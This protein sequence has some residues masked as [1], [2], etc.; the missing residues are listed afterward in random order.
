MNRTLFILVI[1]QSLCLTMSQGSG[2]NPGDMKAQ[3]F[4]IQDR[5]L[6]NT[7]KTENEPLL[8]QSYIRTDTTDN[9]RKKKLKTVRGLSLK[10]KTEINAKRNL[11]VTNDSENGLNRNQNLTNKSPNPKANPDRLLNVLGPKFPIYSAMPINPEN[12]NLPFV[13]GG[14]L[15]PVAQID[16]CN[17]KTLPAVDSAATFSGVVLY[18]YEH[19]L[20]MKHF[21]YFKH[22]ISELKTKIMPMKDSWVVEIVSDD[23]VHSQLSD[24]NASL[25]VYPNLIIGQAPFE[26]VDYDLRCA[27]DVNRSNKGKTSCNNN[28]PKVDEN[29]RLIMKQI[30]SGYHLAINRY[31]KVVNDK[32]PEGALGQKYLVTYDITPNGSVD[33]KSFKQPVGFHMLDEF[34]FVSAANSQKRQKLER[35]LTNEEVKSSNKSANRKLSGGKAD[36]ALKETP[37]V[38]RLTQWIMKNLK[39]SLSQQIPQSCAEDIKKRLEDPYKNTLNTMA[40]CHHDTTALKY[41]GRHGVLAFRID[42]VATK[43]KPWYDQL[44]GIS[45]EKWTEADTIETRHF[46]FYVL[47]MITGTFSQASKFYLYSAYYF[48]SKS[49]ISGDGQSNSDNMFSIPLDSSDNSGVP[50]FSRDNKNNVEYI[51][52][53]SGVSEDIKVCKNAITGIKLGMFEAA[54]KFL[55]AAPPRDLAD[56]VAA[57]RPKNEKIQTNLSEDTD[58]FNTN[59]SQKVE[60]LKSSGNQQQLRTKSAETERNTRSGVVVGKNRG[61]LNR[62]LGKTAAK[63]PE[64]LEAEQELK[65]A[66]SFAWCLTAKAKPPGLKSQGANDCDDLINMVNRFLD[67]DETSQSKMAKKLYS[68]F[69]KCSEKCD[70][71]K[72]SVDFLI[73]FSPEIKH[74]PIITVQATIS[75]T[76]NRNKLISIAGKRSAGSGGKSILDY[77]SLLKIVEVP[78]EDQAYEVIEKVC[79][80]IRL[81]FAGFF[82]G[83]FKCFNFTTNSVDKKN[84]ELDGYLKIYDTVTQ[85]LEIFH[86]YLANLIRTQFTLQAV[87]INIEKLFV[88]GENSNL[89][90]IKNSKIELTAK[91]LLGLEMFGHEKSN[92]DGLHPYASGPITFLINS[93][94]TKNMPVQVRIQSSGATIISVNFKVGSVELNLAIPRIFAAEIEKQTLD[95]ILKFDKLAKIYGELL[96]IKDVNQV[97]D[98]ETVEN[99]PFY[100]FAAEIKKHMNDISTCQ[101]MYFEKTFVKVINGWIDKTFIELITD[102]GSYKAIMTEWGNR[103]Y[104]DDYIGTY[105]DFD[106]EVK[107]WIRKESDFNLFK[108]NIY[109]FDYVLIL[110][111]AVVKYLLENDNSRLISVNPQLKQNPPDTTSETQNVQLDLELYDG[112]A[113]KNWAGNLPDDESEN[114]WLYKDNGNETPKVD[115]SED[116]FGKVKE[117]RE[118]Y[119]FNHVMLIYGI[120][121]VV[122]SDQ[123]PG[124]E[125]GRL[126]RVSLYE[127]R[128]GPLNLVHVI[129]TTQYFMWEYLHGFE[130]Y[131]MLWM[132]MNEALKEVLAQYNDMAK[133]ESNSFKNVSIEFKK[134]GEAVKTD[135]QHLIKVGLCATP[136]MDNIKDDITYYIKIDETGKPKTFDQLKDS[137]CEKTSENHKEFVR[138]AKLYVQDKSAALNRQRY[139]LR[140]YG[141]RFPKNDPPLDSTEI[142][143][144]KIYN[145]FTSHTYSF[146]ATNF[147][148]Y[149]KHIKTYMVKACNQIFK[150]VMKTECQL[151]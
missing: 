107:K 32:G 145:S 24:N 65:C 3:S 18:G 141:L 60:A 61:S 125:L 129:Y 82:R 123:D 86:M 109:G 135:L 144:L 149:E 106:P 7:A 27:I 131:P 40:S 69:M 44:T 59:F 58:L 80:N 114:K 5:G 136:K 11:R 132:Q 63:T 8:K 88:I 142:K 64:E 121:K 52:S 56:D 116:I 100:E 111:D 70:P 33:K 45:Q 110:F 35:K 138:I 115:N 34:Q 12:P 50:S 13:V 74:K 89:A 99:N 151:P 124:Q 42:A 55:S 2:L 46:S 72:F 96:K 39:K 112:P 137:D 85:N 75:T 122:L 147:D 128:A 36:D 73:P 19:L 62:K 17:C 47:Y 1:I 10:K 104:E 113:V 146:T 127:I 133:L 77:E 97:I 118:K 43:N 26:T 126:L 66:Q 23:M 119:D 81:S 4:S 6:Q 20:R 94:K 22:W 140:F 102:E 79:F 31:Y 134:A 38:K 120:K 37:Y 71:G 67:A 41:V 95:V 30:I 25:D 53:R 108:L 117:L 93:E 92:S 15:H 148:G 21:A 78:K 87:R 98:F 54:E 28:L 103:G 49:K 51:I 16:D 84:K 105:S 91:L 139:I 48:P 9:T 83:M 68:L 90:N 29:F 101:S 130:S 76:E 143:S 150:K 14:Y 57:T